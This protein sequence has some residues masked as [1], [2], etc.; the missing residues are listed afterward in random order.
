MQAAAQLFAEKGFHAVGMTELGESLKLGRGTLYHYIQSKE[1]LLFDIS[2]EYISGL[3]AR[4][5]Q[6]VR[7]DPDP[8]SRI[9]ALGNDLIATIA[10]H[11][12]ELKVC[13]REVR[14][15]TGQRQTEVLSLHSTYERIWRNVIKDGERK[16][17]FRAF[18]SVELKGLLGMYFYSYLWMDP[19]GNIGPAGIADRFNGLALRMLQR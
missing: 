14:S 16:E 3:I 19:T 18:D 7:V 4:G 15:L 17:A 1:A 12:Y 10:S 2:R 5:N 8:V 6:L 11:Q 9:R 13:F